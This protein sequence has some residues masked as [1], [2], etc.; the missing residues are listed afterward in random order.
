MS[1]DH[2]R[3]LS[4]AQARWELEHSREAL[5]N[6]IAKATDRGLDPSLY[7]EAALRSTHELQHTEWIE[8]WRRER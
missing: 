3:G 1:Y 2:R 8:R 5:L 7:G 4:A 6:A